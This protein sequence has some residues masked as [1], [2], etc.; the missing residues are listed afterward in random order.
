VLVPTTSASGQSQQAIPK[1]KDQAGIDRRLEKVKKTL[2]DAKSDADQV[3]AALAEID[4]ELATLRASL[5]A[6][7][8]RRADA[9]IATR[10]ASEGL[11]VTTASVRPLLDAIGGR[12]RNTYMVGP[13]GRIEMLVEARN[14]RDLAERTMYLDLAAR[15]QNEQLGELEAA[16]LEVAA[17]KQDVIEAGHDLAE[18]RA[19][20]ESRAKRI[21]EVRALR[22]EAKKELDARVAKLQED[23]DALE[24]E[25]ERIALL[26]RIRQDGFAGVN[27]DAAKGALRWPA[28]CQVTSGFG[29][30]WGR[31]HEGLD[32]ACPHGHPVGAAAAGTILEAGPAGAYGNLVLIDHG[33]GIVT[34]YGHNSAILVSAGEKVK[35]G[36]IIA[37]EG[38][39]GRSTGP[40]IHFEVRINGEPRDPRPFLP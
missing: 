13:A 32:I 29:F 21:R 4:A 2:A 24:A 22:M 1:A 30:R 16:Q 40:H 23:A 11:R 8:D 20:I 34:A 26:I 9:E 3:N 31:R 18:A 33:G 17:A 6:A 15:N 5:A 19:T 10:N 25:S 12:A 28:T 27:P 39:T 36:E 38:S 37:R 35:A 7:K 14:A